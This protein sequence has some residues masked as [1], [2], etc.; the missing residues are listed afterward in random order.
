MGYRELVLADEPL[1][2]WPLND[3]SGTTAMDASGNSRNG[4]L[5]GGVTLQ[6]GITMPDGS[7]GMRFDG[8]SGY[9]SLPP[10][11]LPAGSN[12]WTIECWCVPTNS[13]AGSNNGSLLTI[14]NNGT[15]DGSG[16]ITQHTSGGWFTGTFGHDAGP[17]GISPAGVLAHIVM[18]YDGS[19]LS[20]YQNGILINSRSGGTLALIEG[21]PSIGSTN[22]SYPNAGVPN[23]FFNGGIA[24]VAVYGSALS[25]A[26]IKA[27]YLAGYGALWWNTTEVAGG[28]SDTVTLASAAVWSFNEIAGIPNDSL[29]IQSMGFWSTS[30]LVG[31][32]SEN[33]ILLVES[34][35][36]LV[37]ALGLADTGIMQVPPTTSAQV[38]AVLYNI[39]VGG[40]RIFPQARTLAIANAV[41]RRSTCS[42]V[43]VDSIALVALSGSPS[44]PDGPVANAPGAATAL[45]ALSGGPSGPNGPVANAPGAATLSSELSFSNGASYHF[46]HGQPVSVSDGLGNLVYSGFIDRVKERYVKPGILTSQITCMDNHY[47]ADKRLV[48]CSF[49]NQTADVIVRTLLTNFLAT[50]GISEGVIAPGPVVTQVYFNYI[51][52]AQALDQLAKLSN[53]WWQIDKDKRLHFQPYNA[54]LA[55]WIFDGSQATYGSMIVERGNPGY[56]NR[57]VI[58]GGMELTDTPTETKYGDGASR[59]FSFSYAFAKEPTV[60]LNGRAQLVETKGSPIAARWYWAKGDPILAQNASDA[61]LSANDVLSVTYQGEYPIVVISEDDSMIAQQQYIEGGTSGLV[62]EVEHDPTILSSQDGFAKANALLQRYAA[63]GT[64]ITFKTL[65]GGL[66]PGQLLTV[67]YPPHGLSGVQMLIESVE[68]ADHDGLQLWYTVKAVMGPYDVTWVDFWKSLVELGIPAVDAANLNLAQ[69]IMQS[70]VC[71]ATLSPAASMTITLSNVI[72]AASAAVCSPGTICGPSVIMNGMPQLCG[73]EVKVC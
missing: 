58:L 37:D 24:Q 47:L 70:I 25:A 13:T 27:H 67:N 41:G 38:T 61:V 11:G 4:T 73:P 2:Y 44:G 43:V 30:D 34:A 31:E 5:H 22:Y 54:V 16:F 68:V 32:I 72:F 56:R 12:P 46:Q 65:V 36:T 60:M 48:S 3:A 63:F 21:Y 6:A 52:V 62:E 42:F 9:I 66:A 51:T 29:D 35:W 23:F 33:I 45:V 7:R 69:T 39:T 71:A 19:T 1:G 53:F 8:V 59:A 28:A 49:V 10:S 50:E 18:G 55:P 20:L 15:P 14:G 26:R 40:T 17:Y 57:Q 64:S